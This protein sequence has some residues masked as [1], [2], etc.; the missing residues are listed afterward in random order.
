M[1][2]AKVSLGVLLAALVLSSSVPAAGLYGFE[3]EAEGGIPV[4]TRLNSW[5]RVAT[6]VLDVSGG[7]PATGLANRFVASGWRHLE[8]TL[9][10]CE[11][12]NA[13][14]LDGTSLPQQERRNSQFVDLHNATVVDFEYSPGER[15]VGNRM[16]MPCRFDSAVRRRAR[17]T[18]WV[19]VTRGEVELVGVIPLE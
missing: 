9:D 17:A 5:T 7:G 2:L 14:L 4:T 10:S 8:R 13:R 11:Y 3:P 18:L 15:L 16:T 12:V 1:S 6:Q 19:P